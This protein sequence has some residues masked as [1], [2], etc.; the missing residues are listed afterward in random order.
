VT[1]FAWG[2]FFVIGILYHVFEDT[3]QR[4]ELQRQENPAVEVADRE[5][6]FHTIIRVLYPVTPRAADLTLIMTN[7]LYRD[8]FTARMAE[9]MPL[10]RSD[11]RWGESLAV[12][13]GFIA[14]MLALSCWWFSTRD[15]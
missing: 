8:F 14:V 13:G 10:I 1:C 12:S 6:A 7:G 2:L 11:I 5:N 3:R 4:L 15:Y 9:R